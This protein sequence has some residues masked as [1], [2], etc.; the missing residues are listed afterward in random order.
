MKITLNRDERDALLIH[1]VFVILC[2]FIILIPLNIGIG[3]K[4]FI[5]VVIY[6]LM[7]GVVSIWRKY[8]TWVNIWLFVL[9]I[10]IFQVFPDWFLSAELGILVFPEDGFIKVG[11]VSLYMLLLWVI[12]LFLI[13][14]IGI[15]FQE[16]Y[17]KL[18]A[19]IV[20]ALLSLII[21][22]YT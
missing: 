12:P 15:S 16:R 22:G 10:S 19:Y 14:F 18:N 5:L 8:E 4:L 7:L 21:F 6:N 20:V 3:L 11:T 1:L 9:V 13:T 2:I 17:S